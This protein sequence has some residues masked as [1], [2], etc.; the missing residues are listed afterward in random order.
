[1]ASMSSQRRHL[2][3]PLTVSAL[4][5]PNTLRV[6]RDPEALSFSGTALGVMAAAV[7]VGSVV[8]LAISIGR[9]FSSPQ[10]IRLT[11]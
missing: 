2:I 4:S 11:R 1:M 3:V 6:L 5:L 9:R 8:A 7:F 10:N